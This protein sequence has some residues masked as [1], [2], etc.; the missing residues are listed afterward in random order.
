MNLTLWFIK[1]K[2]ERRKR[3]RMS[4]RTW[5]SKSKTSLLTPLTSTR[6]I[7]FRDLTTSIA[8]IIHFG[9]AMLRDVFLKGDNY[10]KGRYY[11]EITKE[12]FRKLE[13]S[14]Y[15]M[16]EYSV[17]IYR[18]KMLEWDDLAR[19]VVAH[20]LYSPHQRWLVQV[21]RIFFVYRK[22]NMLQNYQETCVTSFIYTPSYCQMI[23]LSEI[24][25]RLSI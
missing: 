3:W 7:P 4:L 18:R 20:K 14:H 11:T 17:S 19:W 8:N 10:I 12:L 24:Q 5:D 21:P 13:K 1:P 15:R 16:A 9:K 25:D 6:A 23:H 2:T 22:L